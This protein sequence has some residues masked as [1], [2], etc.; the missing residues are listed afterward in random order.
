MTSKTTFEGIEKWCSEIKKHTNTSDF[1][2]LL[3]AN[4]IDLEKSR[5]IS[6]EDGMKMATNIGAEYIE[7]SAKTGKDIDTIFKVCLDK[8]NF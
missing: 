6:K 4:K 3:V 7:V 5:V 8:M 1:V 2:I